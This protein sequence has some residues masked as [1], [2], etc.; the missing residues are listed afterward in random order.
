MNGFAGLRHFGAGKS[1]M[2]RRQALQSLALVPDS[3]SDY[4]SVRDRLTRRRF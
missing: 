4:S 3:R 1:T 2:Q